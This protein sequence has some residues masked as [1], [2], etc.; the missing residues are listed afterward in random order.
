VTE[1]TTEFLHFSERKELKELENQKVAR[2][3]S[4]LKGS[5]QEK[6]GLQTV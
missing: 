2:Y 6:M 5:L 1:Y 4:D 3:N